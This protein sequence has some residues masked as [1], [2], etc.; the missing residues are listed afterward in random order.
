MLLDRPRM[1]F[2]MLHAVPDVLN[3][4]YD[5]HGV[6]NPSRIWLLKLLVQRSP[7]GKALSR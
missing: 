7:Y 3:G 6:I 4:L 1:A 5:V 2:G